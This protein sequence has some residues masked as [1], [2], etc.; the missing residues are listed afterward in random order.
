MCL[1]S[2][3][4]FTPG[5]SVLVRGPPLCTSAIIHFCS[6]SRTWDRLRFGHTR[7]QN[8]NTHWKMSMTVTVIACYRFYCCCMTKYLVIQVS[9]VLQK[10][11][12]LAAPRKR[13]Y[14]RKHDMFRTSVMSKVKVCK[15]ESSYTNFRK[16]LVHCTVKPVLKDYWFSWPASLPFCSFL[17]PTFLQNL[18]IFC[19][20]FYGKFSIKLGTR[21]RQVLLYVPT[22]NSFLLNVLHWLGFAVCSSYESKWDWPWNTAFFSIDFHKW[23]VLQFIT[24]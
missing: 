11:S 14:S 16:N 17:L 23:C 1:D 22:L 20:H 18:V 12:P 4:R 13:Q 6:K 19:V 2:L 3:H 7:N 8:R 9:T 5:Q 15:A 24:R 10:Y 21:Q